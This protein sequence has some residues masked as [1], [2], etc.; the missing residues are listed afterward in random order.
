[1]SPY[2]YLSIAI[3]SEVTG[4]LALRSSRSFTVLVPSLVVVASYAL[5]FFMLSLTL[6]NMYVGTAYAIW[7]GVGTAA[8]AIA[9]T[10]LFG[11]RLTIRSAVGIALI[12]VGVLVLEVGVSPERPAAVEHP[13]RESTSWRPPDV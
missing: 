11:E 12:I 13:T 8:V 1:V 5:A 10:I 2:V 7:S 9:G 4:T 3:A 6:R